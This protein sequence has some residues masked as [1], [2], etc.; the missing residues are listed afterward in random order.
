MTRCAPASIRTISPV[1]WLD[2]AVARKQI[3]SAMSSALEARLS[4]TLAMTPS[5]TLTLAIEK[6]ASD[7]RVAPSD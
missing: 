2:R 5:R 1:M 6:P 7:L 3:T 4:G